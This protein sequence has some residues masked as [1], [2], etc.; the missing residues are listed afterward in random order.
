MMMMTI[1][2]IFF[3]RNPNNNCNSGVTYLARKVKMIDF[4]KKCNTERIFLNFN[5]PR[6][7]ELNLRQIIILM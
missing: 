2:S 5:T 3:I 4:E 1:I 7:E 6:I